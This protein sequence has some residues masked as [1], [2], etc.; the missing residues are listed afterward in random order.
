MALKR[1]SS[2]ARSGYEKRFG[3]QDMNIKRSNLKQI[4]GCFILLTLLSGCVV[5]PTSLLMGCGAFVSSGLLLLLLV[6]L[7]LLGV[8][9]SFAGQTVAYY[10]SLAGALIGISL[11]EI[12]ASLENLFRTALFRSIAT[13]FLFSMALF[14]AA[15]VSGVPMPFGYWGVFSFGFVFLLLLGDLYVRASAESIEVRLL[16]K[17]DGEQ[18]FIREQIAKSVQKFRNYQEFQYILFPLAPAVALLLSLI[19]KFGDVPWLQY[20]FMVALSLMAISI[21]VSLVLLAPR[22]ARPINISPCIQLKQYEVESLHKLSSDV[23]T[24]FFTDMF[25][26]LV[27]AAVYLTGA[28]MTLHSV[29]RLTAIP[30]D[31]LLIVPTFFILT[32]AALLFIPYYIGQILSVRSMCLVVDRTDLTMQIHSF[33]KHL[34]DIAAPFPSGTDIKFLLMSLTAGGIL[35][36]LMGKA[37]GILVK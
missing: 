18:L 37:L 19:G 16:D 14:L 34:Y 7:R 8:G 30:K 36:G 31:L 9:A 4:I 32:S 22:L 23:R 35:T 12:D 33:D 26:S 3:L 1:L 15:F 25:H 6:I 20:H 13:A 11:I 21:F 2:L 5:P 24:L 29:D 28:Y 10:L 17:R 27:V